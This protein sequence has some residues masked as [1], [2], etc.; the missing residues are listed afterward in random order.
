MGRTAVM[1]AVEGRVMMILGVADTVK[2]EASLT[3]YTLKKAGL[4]VV[5]LTGDN[6]KTAAAIARQ[7]GISRV[8]AEVLPSHK[9]AKIKNL[10]EKGHK[11]AMIGDGVN[12]SPALAQADIGIAI[13]SGTDVAVEAADV[14]LIRND[15]LDVVACLDLSKKTVNRIW[16]NFLF[17]SIYNLVGIPVAAGVFSPWNFKLHPWMGSA[18]MAL[19]SVS[20][21]VSSLCLKLYRKPVRATLETVEYLKA[22][23]AM[24]ELDTVSIHTGEEDFGISFKKSKSKSLLRFGIEKT[25]SPKMGYLLAENDD[26]DDDDDAMKTSPM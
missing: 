13:G 1:M 14:V 22:M 25:P 10:Q 23:Q 2:P 17:A 19:S 9:V 11:V 18:A 5:L 16:C 12:D 6:K 24:S 7:C 4:E 21:V 3:V 8:Y 15:L 26:S 20:V